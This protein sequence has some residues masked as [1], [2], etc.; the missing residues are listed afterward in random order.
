MET[1]MSSTEPGDAKIS[2]GLTRRTVL[3]TGTA[4][5]AVVAGPVAAAGGGAAA[6]GA[7]LVELI[8]PAGALTAE[9][10]ASMIEGINDV[11][12]G[13]LKQPADPSRRL[14]VQI[15]ETAEGGFGVNGKVFVPRTSR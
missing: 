15:I 10:K 8:V 3:L 11:V 7:P 13:A 5:A 6:F 2:T 12:L 4:A 14:F 9:Q 1:T